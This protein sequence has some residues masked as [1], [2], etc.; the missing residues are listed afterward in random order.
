MIINFSQQYVS[1]TLGTIFTF[2]GGES[3]PPEPPVTFGPGSGS[4]IT[5]RA[6]SAPKAVV[7]SNVKSPLGG[8]RK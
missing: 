1:N 5:I 7:G 3:T 6:S 4:N 8:F 2:S